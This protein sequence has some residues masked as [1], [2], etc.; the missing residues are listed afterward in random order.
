MTRI[1]AVAFAGAMGALVRWAMVSAAGR[2]LPAGFPAG[3]LVVNI[4]G[5]F[6]LG[7]LATLGFERLPLSSV[8]RTAVLVGFLGAFTTFSTFGWETLQ[9]LREGDAV[10]AG[11]NVLLSVGV[12]IVAVWAGVVV[13]SKF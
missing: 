1:S 7:L 5:C 3:T 11:L 10:R 9:L 12:G 4:I 2:W 6:L 13:A 8:T